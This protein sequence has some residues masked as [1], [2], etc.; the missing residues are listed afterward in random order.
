MAE[1]DEDMAVEKKHLVT[2]QSHQHRQGKTA[3]AAVAQG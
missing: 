3:A 1:V 2:A